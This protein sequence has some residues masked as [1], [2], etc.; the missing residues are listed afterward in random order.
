M[1]VFLWG[2]LLRM[3]VSEPTEAALEIPTSCSCLLPPFLRID[4]R[5]TSK[6]EKWAGNL[7]RTKCGVAD[8]T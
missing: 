7:L 4:I 3:L 8:T 2:V 6:L 1:C 5:F